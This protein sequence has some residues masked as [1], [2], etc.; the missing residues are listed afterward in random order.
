MKLS[1]CK[2][3]AENYDAKWEPARSYKMYV[4]GKNENGVA[5]QRICIEH[6]TFVHSTMSRIETNKLAEL[7]LFVCHQLSFTSF[8]REVVHIDTHNFEY[9]DLNTFLEAEKLQT[10][11]NAYNLFHFIEFS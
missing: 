9:F 7:C 4:I 3:C 5:H 2:R 11:K 10:S 6:L 1:L 8:D